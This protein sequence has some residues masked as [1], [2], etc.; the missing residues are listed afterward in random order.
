MRSSMLRGLASYP[1]SVAL[2][3]ARAWKEQC[4]AVPTAHGPV[5]HYLSQDL[6]RAHVQH[7]RQGGIAPRINFHFLNFCDLMKNPGLTTSTSRS[8]RSLSMTV[9]SRQARPTGAAAGTLPCVTRSI[10]TPALGGG[11]ES[12]SHAPVE[13]GKIHSQ[14]FSGTPG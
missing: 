5:V 9:S 13:P 14:A 12:K 3:D 6:L 1:T 4:H 11:A 8:R 7:P 10:A 2:G